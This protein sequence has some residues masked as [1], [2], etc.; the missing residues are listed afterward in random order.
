MKTFCVTVA[1][2]IVFMLFKG[3][4]T[5]LG[6]AKGSVKLGNPNTCSEVKRCLFLLMPGVGKFFSSRAAFGS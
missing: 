2:V 3:V 5:L 1:C 4:T 6:N